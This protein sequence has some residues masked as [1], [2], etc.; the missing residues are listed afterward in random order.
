M[1]YCDFKPIFINDR[2]FYY[3]HV[4]KLS[5]GSMY[6]IGYSV[7]SS[8]ALWYANSYSKENSNNHFSYLVQLTEG[9]NLG[10]LLNFL[11][12]VCILTGKMLQLMLFGELRIIEEEHI[13]ERLPLYIIN[14][15]LNLA[16]KE[17]NLLLNVFLL[18]ISTL[19][20][21]LHLILLDRFDYKQL[22]IANELGSYGSYKPITVLLIYGKNVFFWFNII[23]FVSDFFVAKFLVYD[24]F[25]GIN[26]VTCLL[27][28]FHFAIQGLETL[29][30]FLKNC[31]NIYE[32]AVYPNFSL[33]EDEFD[34]DDIQDEVEDE[35]DE[36]EKVWDT[37]G[38]YTKL[39]EVIF[40][41][42]KIVLF[43]S[44]IY[45]LSYHSGLSVPF[46][47]L[48]GTYMS[49]RL[50]YRELRQLFQFIE[51]SKKLDTQLKNATREDLELT[52]NLCIICR[53]NMRS[54]EDYEDANKKISSS[55][56][57]PKKL[58]C[59]HILHMGCLKDWLE[60]SD[61]C[62]LCR[63]KVFQN[64]EH[65]ETGSTNTANFPGEGAEERG[66]VPQPGATPNVPAQTAA[67]EQTS[68]SS[69][70]PNNSSSTLGLRGSR[71]QEFDQ[72]LRQQQNS[73]ATMANNDENTMHTNT[74]PTPTPTQPTATDN[75]QHIMLPNTAL[76]PPDW[77]LLPIEKSRV[78]GVN[79]TVGI[80]EHTKAN[81]TIINRQRGGELNI[82]DPNFN[83]SMPSSSNNG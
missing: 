74:T 72:L 60:R 14:L 36:R 26:S 38:L 11:I 24:V 81:L 73:R 68:N 41:S 6:L 51:S 64:D 22:Q 49:I 30:Y 46:S 57:K 77:T 28:G 8:G 82:I 5:K 79:Y 27:F 31:L 54:I 19:S 4:M 42:L 43:L 37:K 47:M 56:K 39:I 2:T 3:L 20:K 15:L 13:I 52:D 33:E 12:C 55:R 17:N 53:E 29:S 16:T 50:T 61:N 69:T 7:M 48:Q 21:I 76:I 66:N 67:P 44:F 23:F 58:N 25:Q 75:F 35:D 62:P 40:S 70:T 32:F 45:L 10:I 78:E 65:R 63:R 80:S 71:F 1:Q 9:I 59:G 83:H 18:S 34:L